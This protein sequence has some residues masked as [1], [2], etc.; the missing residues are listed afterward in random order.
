MTSA[1]RRACVRIGKLEEGGHYGTR[2]TSLCRH[3]GKNPSE[4][5]GRCRGWRVREEGMAVRWLPVPSRELG[6]LFCRTLVVFGFSLLPPRPR[7]SCAVATGPVPC[8]PE[9]V[10]RL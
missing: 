2:K 1:G 5:R 9:P 4:L 10:R 6:D 7:C 3:L 8:R